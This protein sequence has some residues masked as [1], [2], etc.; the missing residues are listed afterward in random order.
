MD[1]PS[2]QGPTVSRMQSGERDPN[3]SYFWNLPG[4]QLIGELKMRTINHWNALQNRGLPRL[5]R[6]IYAQAFGMDP[7]TARNTGQSLE[8]CGPQANYIRFRVQLT[9]AH[10]KQRN[11]LAMG[12]RIAYQCVA[13]NNDA[14][15]LAQLPIISSAL[16]HVFREARGEAALIEALAADGFFGQGAVWQRWD[17]DAGDTEQVQ[18]QK[19]AKDPQTGEPIAGPDGAPLLMPPSTEDKRTGLPSYTALY[20]WNLVVEPNTRTSPWIQT[21]EKTSKAELMARYPEKAEQLKR[22]TLT[23]DSEPGMLEL[24]QWDMKSGTDDVL[25]VKHAYHKPSLA[26]PGGRYIGYVD[27]LILWDEPCP[28]ANRIPIK[29]MTSAFYFDTPFGYPES[30]DLLS[31]Q[32]AMDEMFSQGFTNLIKFGNQNLWGED[33]VEFDEQKFA[34]GGAYFTLKTG[35]KPPQ[36]IDWGQMPPLFQYFAERLP[37]LMSKISGISPT[38]L[39]MPE[40]NITSG[41]F[42][43]LMQSIAEKFVSDSQAAFD[44]LVTETGNT[45]LELI[46]ANG[47][48]RFAAKVAGKSNLAY[49]QYF[50]KQD[51]AAVK[52]VEVI[53]Q[54]PVLNNIGGRFEVADRVMKAPKADRRALIM[55]LKTGDDSAITEEDMSNE[56]LIQKEDELLCTGNMSVLQ[57]VVASQVDDHILH[58]RSHVAALSRLRC[59]DPPTAPQE[60]IAWQNAQKFLIKHINEHAMA[61]AQTNP[62]FAAVCSIPPPPMFDPMMGGFTPQAMGTPA[63]A[64]S[65]EPGKGPGPGQMQAAPKLPPGPQETDQPPG[66]NGAPSSNGKDKGA[67]QPAPKPAPQ[68]NGGGGPQ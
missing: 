4:D 60:F 59:M 21:R 1:T 51:F 2:F 64:P 11:Q 63:S 20:P 15:T 43:S 49:M 9:R 29:I 48:V 5:W 17:Q 34:A 50:T 41:V 65:P 16:T 42:A 28:T 26:V 6:L 23:R 7:N 19:P 10:I 62:V 18:V 57:F 58:C 68:P 56:I 31:A 12:P 61:W 39:G 54:S 38:M 46:R 45:T 47:D 40:A 30:C 8:F 13:Q 67:T 53:R 44:D 3:A 22:M 32:E 66:P 35:Q 36:V 33:G 52:C 14:S 55:L 25:S 37:D 24:F 27:D